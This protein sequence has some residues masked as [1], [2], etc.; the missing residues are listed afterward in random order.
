[1]KRLMLVCAFILGAVVVQAQDESRLG[2][3]IRGGV[4]FS[5]FGGGDIQDDDYSN[6]TGFSTGL[7]ATVPLLPFL[8]VEPGVFYSVRGTQNNDFANSR[9][10]LGYV[11]VPVLARLYLG[12][13]FNL[14]AG[15]QVSFLQSSRFEGD[16]FGSTVGFDTDAVRESDF[17]AV[18]GIGFNPAKGLNVQGSYNY[19]MQPVFK[20]SNIDVYNRGFTISVGYTF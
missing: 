8:A 7:Y 10:I 1:M 20:N 14:F 11:D 15:P 3:G 2:I 13:S 9:A 12:D 4:N 6:R 18:V 19:G 16:L 5:T 17:G